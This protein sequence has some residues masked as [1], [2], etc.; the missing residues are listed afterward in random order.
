M[1]SICNAVLPPLDLVQA[2]QALQLGQHQILAQI[3]QKITLEL[4]VNI[5]E[6]QL[7]FYVLISFVVSTILSISKA[8]SQTG[9]GNYQS[10]Y[11]GGFLNNNAAATTDAKIKGKF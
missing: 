11:C 2:F 7:N 3:V 1:L 6:V 5:Y 4:K 9:Y 8:S 10:V